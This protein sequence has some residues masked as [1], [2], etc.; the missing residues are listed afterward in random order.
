MKEQGNRK[1]MLN[2]YNNDDSRKRNES[3]NFKHP[4]YISICTQNYIYIS[5]ECKKASLSI[6]HSDK[7]NA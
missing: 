1:Q 3:Y 2:G 7:C 5:A 4:I 6:T